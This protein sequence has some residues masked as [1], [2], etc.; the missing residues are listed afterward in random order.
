MKKIFTLISIGCLLGLGHASATPAS[1]LPQ[2]SDLSAASLAVP[3]YM[4]S[5]A[6][7]L[8]SR[9]GEGEDPDYWN[10]GVTEVIFNP[11]GKYMAYTKAITGLDW[12]EPLDATLATSVVFGEN[13]EVYFSDLI[14]R[15]MNVSPRTFVKGE[16][17]GDEI[18]VPVPQTVQL[19]GDWGMNIGVMIWDEEDEMYYPIP[20][21]YITY[22][23]NRET[24]VIASKLPDDGR[25]YIIAQMYSFNS[26]WNEMGDF[27]QVYT[28]YET[29]FNEMPENVTTEQYYLN[30][31]Y[32]GYPVEIGTQDDKMYIKGL[33]YDD[34][35]LVVYG[36]VEG[37]TLSIPQN[38]LLGSAYGDF[39]WTKVILEDKVQELVLAPEDAT[40]DMIIDREA[41]TLKSADPN[42]FLAMNGKY[43]SVFYLEV[44]RNIILKVQDS[45]AGIPS[46]PYWLQY[47]G[48]DYRQT[49]GIN[50]L[51]FTMSNISK[52]G[53]VL[54]IDD[55][56]YSIYL[57]GDILEFEST[58]GLNNVTYPGI[59]G[60]ITQVP[61]T[62]TNGYDIKY[63]R[64]NSR[65]IGIY[66]DGV[67][68]VGVQAIYKYDGVVT[69]S[70][71]V[72]LD[73]ETGEITVGA[74]KSIEIDLSQ[75]ESIEYFDLQGRRVSNP[76]DGLYVKRYRMAS[77]E[78]VS[79]KVLI[80]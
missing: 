43:D 10:Q 38:Q 31:N 4:A 76:S 58:D 36:N 75:V 67:S 56:Y 53:N 49:Y 35:R 74:V 3:K 68:T 73:V 55:L 33:S 51:I 64:I 59:E 5:G 14:N 16:I 77:G 70:D 45:F 7:L 21:E 46:D 18:H 2:Y 1:M 69:S 42:E 52:E 39:I 9:A 40:Y 19:Y 61:Y 12:G 24:G 65:Y 37:N 48:D 57:D 25:K 62:F 47:E 80:K 50:A 6:A 71:I 72:T 78:T 30:D 11:T 34:P 15:E 17:V 29:Q 27:T 54:L 23:Y 60:D 44:F 13:N 20:I 8:N 66:P 22:T 79:R 41:K 28:P 63:E 32:Y 26:A